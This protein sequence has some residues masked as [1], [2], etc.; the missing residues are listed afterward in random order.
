MKIRRK[1]LIIT[2]LALLLSTF[3]SSAG[4]IGTIFPRFDN[5]TQRDGLSNNHIQCIYQDHD[6][7]MWFGTSQGLNFYDGYSFELYKN[8]QDDK[9]SIRGELVRT[10]FQDSKNTFW[11]GT[12]HGGLNR[13]DIAAKKF[14]YIPLVGNEEDYYTANSVKEDSKG[15]I[16]IASDNGLLFLNKKGCAE[17]KEITAENFSGIGEIRKIHIDRHDNIWMASRKHGVCVYNPYTNFYKE[18]T[19]PYLHPEDDNVLSLLQ[20]KDGNIWIGTYYS[21]IFV[22]NPQN[23]AIRRLHSFPISERNATVRSIIEDADGL[24]WFGSRGGLLVYDR[25]TEEYGQFFHDMANSISLAHNSII[26]IYIDR[27]GDMWLGTRGGISYMDHDK[28]KF[29]LI[30]EVKNDPHY[31][32]NGEVYAFLEDTKAKRLW[33]GTESGGINVLDMEKNRITYITQKDGLPSDCIKC[34]FNNGSEIWVGTYLGGIAV[35]DASTLKV[36]RI[37]RN[38]PNDPE[39][40]LSNIVWNIYKDSRGLVWIATAKGLDLYNPKDG[41]FSHLKHIKHDSN[42]YWIAEDKDHDL[43]IG[44]GDEVIVYNPQKDDIIRYNERTRSFLQAADGSIWLGTL[45]QGLAKYHKHNGLVRHYSE[46]DGLANDNVQS[47]LTDGSNNIWAATFNGLSKFDPSTCTFKNF[48]EYDGLQD[49]HFHYNAACILSDG[50]IALGGLNGTNIFDPLKMN[51][52]KFE[53]NVLL[54]NLFVFNQPMEIGDNMKENISSAQEV[55]LNYDQNMFSFSFSTLSYS[56]S[57]KNRYKYKM[58]GFDTD[59]IYTENSNRATYTNLNPGT[60]TFSVKGANCDGHW[61]EKTKSIRV[62]I[63]PPFWQTWWFRLLTSLLLLT[64]VFYYIR[65]IIRKERKYSKFQVEKAAY[66]NKKILRK[67]EAKFHTSLSQE[68]KMPLTYIMGAVTEI[69]RQKPTEALILDSAQTAEKNL[70]QVL[71]MLNHTPDF[72]SMETDG[73]QLQYTTCDLSEFVYSIVQLY[74]VKAEEYKILVL[75]EKPETQTVTRTDEPKLKHILSS[76]LE[77]AV[78]HTNK[79]GTVLVGL[80]HKTDKSFLITLNADGMKIKGDMDVLKIGDDGNPIT[81]GLIRKMAKSMNC[82][83]SAETID[84]HGQTNIIISLPKNGTMESDMVTTNACNN[85]ITILIAENDI[86][87]CSYLKH[88]LSDFGSISIADNGDTTFTMAA[89]R[90]PD[91]II[92]NW[93]LPNTNNGILCKQLKSDERTKYIYV[94]VYSPIE[95]GDLAYESGANFYTTIPFDVWRLKLLINNLI[96]TR[97]CL[98]QKYKMEI[99]QEPN[100][101]Q[102]ESPD[103]K[104][105]ARIMSVIEKNLSDSEFGIEKFAQEVGL[106]RMQLYRKIDLL[107][108]MTVKEFIRYIRIKRAVQMLEQN[109]LTVSEVAYEVGFKDISYFRKCFK[110]QT[111]KKPSDLQS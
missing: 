65:H 72:E 19:V 15:V 10:I 8:H 109:K 6:G 66:Q 82:K 1:A 47:L 32:N 67:R 24:L 38:N 85:G 102:L 76:L 62:V 27:K 92:L 48:D 23:Y 87:F 106:S 69:I 36:K 99:L 18:I 51:D 101:V 9:N 16:W 108:N 77:Y 54:R 84:G 5:F 4:R 70:E 34:F 93:N 100:N 73:S 12:E 104:L 46:K 53:A 14:S 45:S 78:R 31:L 13:F 22:I 35:V 64:F 56:K 60:Y 26:D 37:I 20:T 25:K 28:M 74:T 57:K 107:T 58:S 80:Q 71:T 63:L 29:R 110:A 2:I 44:S 61:N 17:Q 33:I 52:S 75:F 40:L 43:W 39:S 97:S 50:K 3:P 49:N 96:A 94:V 88:H 79:E 111:G 7:R 83:I 89:D 103:E 68:L 59:W 30:N 41:S 86:T 90:Q 105:M 95:I 11:V 98:K 91:I 81:F 55:V 42:V 21:G